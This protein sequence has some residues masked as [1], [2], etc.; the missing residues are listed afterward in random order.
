M[1]I[2]PLFDRVVLEEEKE[3]TS[4]SGIFLGNANSDA[5]KIG[6]VLYV[7]EGNENSDGNKSKM[8]V[9]AGDRVLYNKY[10]AADTVIDD[11]HV[12]II[13]QTD[14]LAIIEK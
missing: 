7:G 9:C 12:L 6:R 5:P 1:K 14:I 13:R 4:K 11:K 10:A 2:K 8:Y 3:E